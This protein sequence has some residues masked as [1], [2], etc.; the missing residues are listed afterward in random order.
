MRDSTNLV[1]IR[2]AHKKCIQSNV[3]E[4]L[5]FVRHV[6]NYRDSKTFLLDLKIRL[7][8]YSFKFFF[9]I[10]SFNVR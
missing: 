5:C 1:G 6:L 7:N 4:F 9:L 2:T 3:Y 10:N 8:M